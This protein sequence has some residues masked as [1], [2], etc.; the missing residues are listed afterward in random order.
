V[1]W[2]WSAQTQFKLFGSYPLPY[3]IVVSGIYRNEAALRSAA[4]GQTLS[5]E[6]NWAVPNSVI[7]PSLGR[8]LAGGARTAT[9]PLVAPYTMFEDRL[10]QLDLRVSKNIRMGRTRLQANVDLYNALNASPVTGVIG[11]YGPRWLQPNQILE[12]RLIQLSGQLTF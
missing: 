7:A 3:D 2:P 12:G 9:V 8:S 6:A 4:G 5:I 10:N 11:T 1:V